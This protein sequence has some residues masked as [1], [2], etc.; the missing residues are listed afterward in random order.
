[1]AM[2]GCAIEVAIFFERHSR[3]LSWR[4]CRLAWGSSPAHP[5]RCTA[6][7]QATLTTIRITNPG[8]FIFDISKS[9]KD[10]TRLDHASPPGPRG[11]HQTLHTY[12]DRLPHTSPCRTHSPSY[13]LSTSPSSRTTS[14]PH[15]A[16][17]PVSRTIPPPSAPWS[18]SFYT[19]HS[20]SL[21]KYNGALL[22]PVAPHPCILSTS[23]NTR[24][25]SCR[26]GSPAAI[27]ASS[28]S[29]D[30]GTKAWG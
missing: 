8:A 7:H 9:Q 24:T 10:C 2:L 5:T 26:A 21:K 17:A 27:H 4:A 3:G 14:V 22:H 12:T 23:T 29:Q 16:A 13:R 1:L 11:A 18:R 19:R 15:A 25:A 20:I 30:R 6:K 28:Y